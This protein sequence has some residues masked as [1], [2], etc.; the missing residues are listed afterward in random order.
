MLFMW[1]VPVLVCLMGVVLVGL[2]VEWAMPVSRKRSVALHYTREARVREARAS[3]ESDARWERLV[4]YS[5]WLQDNNPICRVHE[6]SYARM[7]KRAEWDD[8]TQR[9]ND[10]GLEGALELRAKMLKWKA[11]NVV[12]W[13]DFITEALAK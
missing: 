12:E 1:I 6:A 13:E 9:V 4:R 8:L 11:E 2:L 3:A 10:P 7:A 5:H